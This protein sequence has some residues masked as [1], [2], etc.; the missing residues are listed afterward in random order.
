[1]DTTATGTKV[2]LLDFVSNHPNLSAE[3]KEAL[4]VLSKGAD[5][6]ASN[7]A[8]T[9]ELAGIALKYSDIELFKMAMTE[10]PEGRDAFLHL[11]PTQ[12]ELFQ[13][14]WRNAHLNNLDQT[15]KDGS[16]LAAISFLARSLGL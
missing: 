12:T 5:T 16:D 9:R 14:G 11:G 1:E 8:L 10:S 13:Q 6:R 3:T 7:P 15:A 4:V 2:N